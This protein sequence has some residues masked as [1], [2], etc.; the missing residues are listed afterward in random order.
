MLKKGQIIS[1]ITENLAY[2]GDAVGHYNGQAVFVPYGVPG[3]E[4]KTMVSIPHR[5]YCRGSISEIVKPSADRIDPACRYFGTCGSCQWQMMGYEYQI[6]QKVNITEEIFKRLAG[7]D[8]PEIEALKH[9]TG[10]HYRN[11]AQYPVQSGKPGNK[12][13]YYQ[14]KSHSIV[15]IDSCPLVGD[16]INQ[17]FAA[18]KDIINDSGLKGYNESNHSGSLR[19]LIFRYSR[20]QDA[21]SLVLVTRYEPDLSKISHRIMA[22]MPFVK[23]VW[24]N[25]NRKRGNSILGEKWR[26]L[27]G[28]EYLIEGIGQVKYRMSPGSFLQSNLE[29]AEMV[30]QRMIEDLSLGPGDILSD[31]YSGMGSIAL[32]L[33]GKVKKV[34]AIEEFAPAVED[35]R[36]NAVLNGIENCEFLCGKSEDLISSIK[37]AD[38]VVLDPP[39]QG[40]EQEV[41]K[42]ILKLDPG[43]IAYLSCN[44]STLAR[45]TALLVS[46]GYRLKKLYLADMFPQTYHIENLAI[47]TR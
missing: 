43:R 11:K 38:A 17:A 26:H 4:L 45:D 41:I 29:M 24:Q 22:E 25:I 2:G 1:L 21:L 7:I 33:A 32:Q 28:E 40:A 9:S 12:M 14:T 18:V 36:A 16:K 15:D 39:R 44:P 20:H 10:W 30:Y 23:S 34:A 46:G 19:H 6:Q 5:T 31:L 37:T 8:V 13:G 47:L 42:A 27:G 35:A 3:D